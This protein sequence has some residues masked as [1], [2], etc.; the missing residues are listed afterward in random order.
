ML[1][2]EK[3]RSNFAPLAGWGLISIFDIAQVIAI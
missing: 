1:N 2:A 3:T